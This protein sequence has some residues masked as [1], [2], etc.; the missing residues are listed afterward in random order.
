MGICYGAAL[1]MSG[2]DC[3]YTFGYVGS[4]LQY[5]QYFGHSR[6]VHV[7]AVLAVLRDY[8]GNT[9]IDAVVSSKDSGRGTE[10]TAADLGTPNNGGS[11]IFHPGSGRIV[12]DI[13]DNLGR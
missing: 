8:N 2:G 5:V 4:F 13:S 9:G 3:L 7:L 10:A 1:Y 12:V 6:S 11:T